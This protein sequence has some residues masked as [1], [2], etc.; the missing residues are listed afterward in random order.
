MKFSCIQENLFKGLQVVSHIAGSSSGLPILANI[1]LKT[2]DGFLTLCSTN[3]EMGVKCTVRGKVEVDGVVAIDA[4]VI[5]E[6]I[7][8]LPKDRVELEVL[9]DCVLSITCGT[10]HTK[11]KGVITDEYPI[12]PPAEKANALQC[13]AK[14]LKKNLQRTVGAA[15]YD[16]ARMELSGVLFV[17]TEKKLTLAAT[18]AYRLAESSLSLEEAAPSDVR[19]I[20]PL[21]TVQE[22]L[23]NLTDDHDV[24]VNLM[25][26]DTQL[27][28]VIDTTELVSK[29][30]DGQYPDYTQIIPSSFSTRAV[31]DRQD[32]IRAVKA[33]SIFSK[34][35]L[36]D[37]TLSIEPGES[38]KG[39]LTVSSANTTVGETAVRLDIQC[40]GSP[41]SMSLNYRYLLDGLQNMTTGQVSVGAIDSNSPCV[42]KPVNEEGYQ[43]MVMP[44]RE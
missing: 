17:A 33:S 1:L 16:E 27:T 35:G 3:L 15:K 13:K 29:L 31:V 38:D 36:N 23:R 34:S 41:I 30:I 5:T 11:I 20:V 24:M 9:E 7:G 28:A 14:D 4:R 42:L 18:D 32:W 39:I 12:L 19:V 37:V 21:K 10:Y 8:L 43:Y 25:I 40:S 6:Y 26:S 44:I 2:E 22:L